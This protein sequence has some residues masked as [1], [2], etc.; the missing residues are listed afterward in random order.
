M[1]SVETISAVLL[2]FAANRFFTSYTDII[3]AEHPMPE[4]LYALISD[5]SLN[6]LITMEHSEGVGEKREQLITSML[7]S[8]TFVLVLASTLRTQ[9]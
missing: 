2:G 1:I 3:P 5:R 6:S 4:R 7:I 8:F 9:S